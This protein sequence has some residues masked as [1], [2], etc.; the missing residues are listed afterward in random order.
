MRLAQN[1]QGIV[2]H[3]HRVGIDS[4]ALRMPTI[5]PLKVT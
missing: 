1:G 5:L 3:H 4:V 2:L